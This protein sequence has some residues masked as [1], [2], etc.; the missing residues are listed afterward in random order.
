MTII[1]KKEATIAIPMALFK[2]D[3]QSVMHSISPRL[4]AQTHFT[5]LMQC[6]LY[7]IH[8]KQGTTGGFTYLT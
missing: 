2:Q 1:Y 3:T 5:T 7:I 6:Y 8:T 4:K